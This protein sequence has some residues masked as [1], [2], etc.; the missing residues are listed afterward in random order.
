VLPGA[1]PLLRLLIDVKTAL[2]RQNSRTLCD[3]LLKQQF[4]M[5][6]DLLSG[7]Q[8]QA[9]WI[10]T[11]KQVVIT[12]DAA[13][14]GFGAFMVQDRRASAF[15]GRWDDQ[16]ITA[17]QMCYAELF[18]LVYAAHFWRHRLRNRRV[19]FR[20]DNIAAVFAVNR[21]RARSP[22]LKML[23]V[24]LALLANELNCTFHAVHVPG[25]DN[26]LADFLS[27]PRRHRYV[28]SDIYT[29]LARVASTSSFAFVKSSRLQ[30][31]AVAR[32]SA[33]AQRAANASTVPVA[34]VPKR[35]VWSSSTWL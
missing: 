32:R 19:L 16:R 34:P 25:V 14:S 2:P 26:D 13:C 23:M 10:P 27:R 35:C 28:R 24:S 21:M 15:V 17:P 18:S 11:G 8:P 20:C 12:S 4:R 6:A 9:H 31:H 29:H 33:R 7:W 5:W 1:R 22:Q 30:L 3:S